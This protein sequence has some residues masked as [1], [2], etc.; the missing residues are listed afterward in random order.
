MATLCT[1]D[2]FWMFCVAFSTM[3]SSRPM[4]RAQ[5]LS[6]SAWAGTTP[7]SQ[8]TVNYILRGSCPHLRGSRYLTSIPETVQISLQG[9]LG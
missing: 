4:P 7:R 5:L 8:I 6:S 2:S 1:M 9:L 3:S